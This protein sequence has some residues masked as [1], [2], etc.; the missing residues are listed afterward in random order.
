VI[1]D[2]R[3]AFC[4]TLPDML[5]AILDIDNLHVTGNNVLYGNGAG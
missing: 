1:R 3:I 2:I 5:A 4:D